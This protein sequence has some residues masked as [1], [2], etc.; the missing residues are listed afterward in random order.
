[1]L[2][3]GVVGAAGMLGLWT[4]AASLSSSH[5]ALSSGALRESSSPVADLLAAADTPPDTGVAAANST[6]LEILQQIDTSML[7]QANQPAA[8]GP[9]LLR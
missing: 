2:A 3:A 5:P 4:A 8:G 7:P 6:K 1:M 9:R